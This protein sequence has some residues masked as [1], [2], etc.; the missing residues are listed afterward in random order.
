LDEKLLRQALQKI[1]QP[2]KEKIM[3]GLEEI[4]PEIRKMKEKEL[5]ETIFAVS[6]LFYT[7]PIERP[8]YQEVVDKATQIVA[9]LKNKSFPYLFSMMLDSDFKKDFNIAKTFGLIGEES[10][11]PLLDVFK[12]SKDQSQRTFILYALGKIKNLKVKMA[13]PVLLEALDDKNREIRDSAARTIGKTMEVIPPDQLTKDEKSQ[14]FE[15]LVRKLSDEGHGVR[16]KAIRSLGKMA[17]FNFLDDEQIKRLKEIVDR[18]LGIDESYQWDRAYI[19]R[20]EAQQI[21]DFL[22]N[23]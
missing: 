19:V 23:K 2:E 20:K 15:N 17:R 7:D 18:T 1:A 12:K 6:S 14:V 10:I 5:K 13:L 3:E 16:S 21:F 4:E 8:D 22:K 11:Q 9:S